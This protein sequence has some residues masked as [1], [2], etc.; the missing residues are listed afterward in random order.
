MCCRVPKDAAQATVRKLQAARYP[1]AC[2][3]GTVLDLR[4]A[5]VTGNGNA[6]GTDA[7]MSMAMPEAS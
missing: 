5:A 2:I 6:L 1:Q 4:Q 3:I 7:I